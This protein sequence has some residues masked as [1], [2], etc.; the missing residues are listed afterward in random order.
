MSKITSNTKQVN[1]Q[2]ADAGIGIQVKRG[3]FEG[4]LII[5]ANH[6]YDDADAIFEKGELLSLEQ[7]Q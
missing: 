5:P 4:R 3:E 1:Y 6:N 7:L 2:K